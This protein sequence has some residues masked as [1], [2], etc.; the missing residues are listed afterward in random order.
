LLILDEPT[1]N[2]DP[3]VRST[4]I[5]LV[6]EARAAGTTVVFSSHVLAEIEEACDRVAI[7]RA[8]RLVHV[9]QMEQLRLRHFISARCAGQIPA[10]PVEFASQLQIHGDG[11]QRILIE[12]NGQLGPVLGWLATLPLDDVR[13]EPLGLRA[14][15]DRMQSSPLGDAV[16]PKECAE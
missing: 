13:I 15:Y 1:S 12:A 4:V 5:E 7:L 11:G 14:I 16:A 9:Q 6:K 10:P 3:T 8:G 2:L